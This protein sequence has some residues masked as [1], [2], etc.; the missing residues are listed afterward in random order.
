VPT[1][2]AEDVVRSAFAIAQATVKAASGAAHSQPEGTPTAG[3]S[4]QGPTPAK[5]PPIF[6]NPA[7]ATV[8]SR[9][10]KQYTVHGVPVAAPYRQLPRGPLPEHAVERRFIGSGKFNVVHTRRNPAAT[11]LVKR[12]IHAADMD[13][14]R[15][16]CRVLNE[17]AQ[18][19]AAPG[20]ERF[21]NHFA[22]EILKE[23]DATGRA[24]FYTPLVN[25]F[26]LDRYFEHPEMFSP[27]V[28]ARKLWRES[29]RLQNAI[30]W[31]FSKGLLHGDPNPGNIMYDLGL[32]K[33]VLIDFDC[34]N[35]TTDPDDLQQCLDLV[36]HRVKARLGYAHP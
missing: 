13:E 1:F 2:H 24:V 11:V 23:V 34:I 25:G 33:L 27:L 15:L 20:A 16:R 29:T 3:P 36:E 30:R 28:S 31:L 17:L 12:S 8:K 4:A 32:R 18:C 26:S 14:I 35:Q 21:R 5:L 7:L 19:L 9:S 22:P 6:V 10:L